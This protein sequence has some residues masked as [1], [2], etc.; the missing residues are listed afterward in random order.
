MKTDA[1]EKAKKL[2]EAIGF[3]HGFDIKKRVLRI[4]GRR[5]LCYFIIGYTDQL[6]TEGIL[7][8]LQKMPVSDAV[9]LETLLREH[10]PF[11]GGE[12]LLSTEAAAE[13]LLRG[14]TV[15][16]V[17]GAEGFLILDLRSFSLRGTEE[18][19]KDRTLRGPHVGMNESLISNLI[20]IRRYLRTPLFR[21]ERILMGKK[22]KTEVAILSL[23]GKCD[24]RLL[25]TLRK[26]LRTAPLPALS[27]TQENLASILFPQ[28]GW[29]LM[30]P[31][32]RVR[33][34]ERPDVVAATLLEGKIAILCDNS[35]SAILLP[36][37]IFDFFEEADDYYFPPGVASYLRLVRAAVFACSIFLIPIWLLIVQNEG[38]L[39]DP[40]RFILAEGDYAV[41]LFLQFIIIELCLDGL[42]MASLNTP[43]T[44]SNSFSVIGGLLLGEFAVKSGWF[45]PHVVWPYCS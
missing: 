7:S 2:E 24:E 39:P 36:E 8:A 1:D 38:I 34:T 4:G 35:P 28:R 41:P 11:G 23:K 14:S 25:E 37:C 22:V 21:T 3:S 6:L 44:L 20:Q 45:V 33:Y 15:L 42:K 40:F 10:I 9:S 43:S 16:T 27:M 19:E 26:R 17:E 5:A 32:P 30:N 31:F 18:P 12:I 13:E 29:A